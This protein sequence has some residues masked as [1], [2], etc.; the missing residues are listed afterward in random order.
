MLP[1][2]RPIRAKVQKRVLHTG[3]SCLAVRLLKA[4]QKRFEP[5]LLLELCFPRPFH[6]LAMLGISLPAVIVSLLGQ[7]LDS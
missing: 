1:L 4:D 3:V 5:V 6:F 2:S 7:Y